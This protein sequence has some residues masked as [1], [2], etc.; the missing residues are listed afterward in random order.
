MERPL[1]SVAGAR[2][3]NTRL[4]SMLRS[5]HFGQEIAGDAGGI[6]TS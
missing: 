5:D 1:A 4:A 6:S 2:E 3:E